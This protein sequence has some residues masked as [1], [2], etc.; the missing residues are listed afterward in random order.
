MNTDALKQAA[1]K[2][3]AS[4][5][6]LQAIAAA[7]KRERDRLRQEKLRRAAGM[8]DRESY[9]AEHSISSL[10][11]WVAAGMSRA[12]WYRLMRETGPSPILQNNRTRDTPVSKDDVPPMP[13]KIYVGRTRVA[14]LAGG[15]GHHAPAGF[16]GAAP[17]GSGE[18]QEEQ[19]A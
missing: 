18:M 14:G 6:D 1:S 2:C 9:L 19:A 4:I 16:Q 12:K 13:A 3:L 7:K 11:P 8:Q 5:V 17:H 15:L 10:K